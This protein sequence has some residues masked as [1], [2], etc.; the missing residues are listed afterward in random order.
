MTGSFHLLPEESTLLHSVS[1]RTPVDG[2]PYRELANHD[3]WLIVYQ[4][5][6]S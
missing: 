2:T 4:E 5:V 3:P 1:H 6:D